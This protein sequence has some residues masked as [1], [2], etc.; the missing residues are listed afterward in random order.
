ML[1]AFMEQHMNRTPSHIDYID[2]YHD[3]QLCEII[4][5]TIDLAR[6]GI[7]AVEK[8]SFS[9]YYLADRQTPK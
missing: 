2:V 7:R 6:H 1:N 4:K 8:E 5:T 9:S 3:E